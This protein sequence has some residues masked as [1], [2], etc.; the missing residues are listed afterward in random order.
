MVAVEVVVL[1][2]E[3]G[4]AKAK[5]TAMTDIPIKPVRYEMC[6]AASVPAG[7]PGARAWG[8]VGSAARTNKANNRGTR[9]MDRS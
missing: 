9:S 8:H 7:F 1:V 6:W 2:D 4:T 5:A 3:P